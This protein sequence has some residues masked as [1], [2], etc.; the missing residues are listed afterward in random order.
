MYMG[1][2]TWQHIIFLQPDAQIFYKN[3]SHIYELDDW[4]RLTEAMG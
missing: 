2:L 1:V 4:K 3:V